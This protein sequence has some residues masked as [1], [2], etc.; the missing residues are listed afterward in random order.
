MNF[1]FL[2][3]IVPALDYLTTSNRKGLG[4]AV[5]ANELDADGKDVV[6]IGGGDTAM[7]CVRTAIRQG[8][9]SVACVYRRDQA[10]MPG[11]QREVQNAMEEGVTFQWL[12]APEEFLRNAAGDVTHLRAQRMRLSSPDAT[13]RQGIE[14]IEGASVDLKADLAI[15]ALGFDPEDLPALFAQPDLPVSRWGTVQVSWQTFQVKDMPGVFAAGDIVRGASLVV[16]AV[17]DGRDAAA[18]IGA[19]LDEQALPKAAE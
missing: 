12:H 13:G 5:A 6:V 11:S 17:K 2:G 14:A 19:Y 18:A 8:A 15:K 10:N 9:K 3:N 16:W 4:D 7:D 1:R